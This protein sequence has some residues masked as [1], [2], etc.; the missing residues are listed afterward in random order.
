[1]AT[2]PC[3]VIPGGLF[4][5]SAVDLLQLYR[6]NYLCLQ[7]TAA[8]LMEFSIGLVLVLGKLF[9]MLLAACSLLL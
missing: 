6:A 1:M 5:L 9:H 7:M 4:S 2:T 8:V 3:L